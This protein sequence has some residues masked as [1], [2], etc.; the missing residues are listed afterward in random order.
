[1]SK[2]RYI[3]ED[4]IDE[5]RKGFQMFDVENNGHVNPIELKETMEEMNLKEKNPFIYELISSLCKNFRSKEG[6]TADEFISILN[7]KTFD[8]ETN[9]G[10][11][12]IFEVFSDSDNKISM[13]AFYQIAKEVG[14]EGNGEE[15]K[16]LVEKSK[17]GGKEIDFNEFYDIMKDKNLI[18]KNNQYSHKRSKSGNS[19]RSKSKGK[20]TAKKDNDYEYENNYLNKYTPKFKEINTDE[21]KSGEAIIRNLANEKV[22]DDSEKVNLYLF[23]IDKEGKGKE[24]NNYTYQGKRK[25]I[26]EDNNKGEIFEKNQVKTYK[27]RFIDN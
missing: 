13:P 10:I 25:N 11:K 14:D 18:F 5:I 15:I 1:M 20:N 7:E 24:K 19:N 8:V 3:L 2:L 27:R 17:T 21:K 23:K 12:T 16:E 22:N 26:D 6:L 4:D 9:Q